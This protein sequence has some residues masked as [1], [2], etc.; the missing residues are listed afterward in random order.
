M[1]LKCLPIEAD[2]NDAKFMARSVAQLSSITVIQVYH[3]LVLGLGPPL[4]TTNLDRCK[5]GKSPC[6]GAR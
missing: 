5:L 6:P 3:V 2:V 1:V 4:T